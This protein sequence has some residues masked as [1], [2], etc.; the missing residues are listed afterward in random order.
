MGT[1]WCVDLNF[2]LSVSYCTYGPSILRSGLVGSGQ[3]FLFFFFALS[4]FLMLG[5]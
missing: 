1:G 4:E 2:F 3:G 5:F